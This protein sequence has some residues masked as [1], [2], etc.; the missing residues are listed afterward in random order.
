MWQVVTRCYFILY[1]NT[2]SEYQG[3]AL[4]SMDQSHS[5]KK[6]KQT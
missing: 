2:S 5:S 4:K 1:E 6:F 3:Q